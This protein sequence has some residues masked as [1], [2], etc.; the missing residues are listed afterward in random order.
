MSEWR[1]LHNPDR[2]FQAQTGAGQKCL[3]NFGGCGEYCIPDHPCG[4]CLAAEVERLTAKLQAVRD[5]Y[6]GAL[7]TRDRRTHEALAA[8]H[9]P[10]FMWQCACCERI[11]AILRDG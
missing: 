6:A 10:E 5:Q 3:R 4:C 8:L 9:Q 7:A 11:R 2:H 1:G